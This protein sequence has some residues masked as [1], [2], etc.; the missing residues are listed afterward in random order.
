MTYR[1]GQDC[2][3]LPANIALLDNWDDKAPGVEFVEEKLTF[4]V[5][6]VSKFEDAREDW[7]KRAYF[8][9]NETGTVEVTC[10]F[11]MTGDRRI[12]SPDMPTISFRG[13]RGSLRNMAPGLDGCVYA[14]IFRNERDSFTPIWKLYLDVLTPYGEQRRREGGTLRGQGGTLPWPSL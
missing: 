9:L 2:G 5:L 11:V 7:A 8:H 3:P 12:P 10:K 14:L 6:C 1:V 13:A 4:R